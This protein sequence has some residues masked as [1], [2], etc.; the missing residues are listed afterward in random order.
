MNIKD[1]KESLE[2][3][4]KAELTPFIWGHAGIGKS[5]IVKQYAESMGF[6]FFPF[7]LGTQSD[8]G[9][10]L[11]LAEFTE[12]QD[13][14]KSTVF[15]K[16]KWMQELIE[17]CEENPASG[18]II[19]L[20][21]FNRARRDILSGMFSLALDKTFHTIRLPKNC[22]VIA[23][24]NPPTD[25][26]FTTDI[27]E[28]ALM[29]RFAHVKLDPTFEEWLEYAKTKNFNPTLIEFY[30]N[31]P[32][33]LEDKRQDYKLPVKVD[34]RSSER[35][36]KL[37]DVKTPYYLIEQLMIGIIGLER[38]VAYQQ[39]LKDSDKPLTAEEVLTGQKRHLIEKWSNPKDIS[40]SL[41][42]LTCENV[43]E[44][45]KNRS[46]N[47]VLLPVDEKNH[48]MSF[49]ELVPKDIA[50]PLIEK[51]V[52]LR[53]KLCLDFFSDPSYE[54]RLQEIIRIARGK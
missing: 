18:A 17:Y 39:F 2:F 1:F 46:K 37:F 41:L 20:D 31:Q 9:D 45:V 54:T 42:N 40:G 36:N 29:A 35:L 14:S 23:A 48:L 12:N 8:I 15:A 32:D 19:F 5:S 44:F 4:T 7:Y 43:M 21:E 22:H 10:V 28:T 50:F 6:K 11:G 34:R 47:E 53:T 25:E 33:L 30:R 13:G 16:P 38:T 24:G 3:L 26:Y 52:R 27:N 49:I 51:I